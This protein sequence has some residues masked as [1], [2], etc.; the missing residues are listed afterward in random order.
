[1]S[2]RWMIYGAT[3]YTGQL[4]ASRSLARGLSPLLA[5][6]DEARLRRLA[7]PLGFAHRA[8]RL[9][10]AA[11]L[12]RLLRGVRLVLNAAG[13][14]AD[15]AGPLVA[16][17]LAT[18]AHYL[19]VT[20]EPAVFAALRS[21][22]GAARR[23]GV[24]LLPGAGFVVVATDCLAAHVARRLPGAVRLRLG[25]SVP[26]SYAAH[27]SLRTAIRHL[28]PG[29]RVRRGGRLAVPPCPLEHDFDYG[30]GRRTGLAVD[31]AD[32][33]TAWHTTGIPDVEV[34]LDLLP[35]ERAALTAARLFAGWLRS[36]LGQTLVRAKEQ[37]LPRGA[38]PADRRRAG[39]AVVAE[40]EDP[41]G[42]RAV[43]R[44][45]TPDQY[46]FTAAAALTLVERV[47][48]GELSPG[49][50]TPARVYGADFV[51]GFDGVSREDLA[52]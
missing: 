28:V 49:F 33:V 23:R 50:Q 20:G 2:E 34:Y 32:V 25:V 48:A 7:E 9:D 15:T 16:A 3:G 10:D 38:P 27:G 41:A 14:F 39:C 24:M 45:H 4:L 1:M 17:C 12:A 47:L 44:L 52:G 26:A 30:W 19:D 37:A 51:L 46:T 35:R 21:R 29:V 22:D 6:R 31:W 42:R 5:G 40:A 18:G 13:P 11:A 36:P 8:A 43:S